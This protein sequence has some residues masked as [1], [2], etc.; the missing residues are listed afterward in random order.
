MNGI[1]GHA[2]PTSLQNRNAP[3]IPTVAK[4]LFGSGAAACCAPTGSGRILQP[5]H[6]LLLEPRFSG[7]LV[8]RPI[9]GDC[10]FR[11]SGRSDRSTSPDRCSAFTQRDSPATQSES[12]RAPVGFGAVGNHG[13]AGR[14][15]RGPKFVEDGTVR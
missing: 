8:P 11:I 2:K 9:V 5:V 10:A 6:L 13:G 15:A 1:P 14:S 7:I 3:V 4:A 12:N